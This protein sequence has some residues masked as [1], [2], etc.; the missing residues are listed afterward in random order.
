VNRDAL[1]R[2]TIGLPR[3]YLTLLDEAGRRVHGD[4]E[5]ISPENLREGVRG[6]AEMLLEMAAA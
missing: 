1:G 6:H 3:Q 5:R 4:D 2:E